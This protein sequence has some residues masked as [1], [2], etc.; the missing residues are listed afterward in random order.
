M[1]HVKRQPYEI[2]EV[3]VTRTLQH[4]RKVS[5][6]GKLP[7]LELDGERI[8]DSTDIAHRLEARFPDPPLVPRDPHEAALCHVLEDW[9]D[10]SLYFY[11]MALRFTLPAN[12]KRFA[13]ELLAHDP[14]W[15][16]RLLAPLVPRLMRRTTRSQGVGRK[17]LAMLLRDVERHVDALG[18]LLHGGPEGA[19][20]PGGPGG[21]GAP[22]ETRAA[23]ESGWLVGGR[24]SLADLAVFAQL[25]CIRATDE[26]GRIVGDRPT[27]AAWMERVDRASGPPADARPEG[28]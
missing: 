17:P 14:P 7:C 22:P 6:I 12:A 2:V 27:V 4:L 18:G 26:G 1:L 25:A 13:P 5:K 16:Q 8:A 23:R 9:A 24:L 20:T 10:E 15:A 3:P 21:P 28:A 19:V 11:E